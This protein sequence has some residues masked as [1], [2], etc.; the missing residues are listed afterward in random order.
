MK[1]YLANR[2][3][4]APAL[5]NAR[6]H[7]HDIFDITDGDRAPGQL[8]ALSS[9]LRND[10]GDVDLVA[11]GPPCQGFSGIGHRRTFTGLQ[12][13]EIPSN[14]LYR[15]MAAF[16]AA[17]RPKLF[18]FENVKGLLSSRWTAEGTKGEVWADVRA[19]LGNIPERH[20]SPGYD[21]RWAVVQAKDYGVPQN[22]PRVLLVG[23]RRDLGWSPSDGIAD[24]LLP[25][26]AGERSP[27]PCDFLGDL[28]DPDYAAKTATLTY[29]LPAVSEMQ[30]W[31]RTDV[32]G[33]VAQI[34][35]PLTE[36]EYS[37]HAPRIVQK[38][39][40]MLRTGTIREEDRTKKFA[41]RVLPRR[42]GDR[43][44]TITATSLPDDYVHFEQPRILTVREWARLQ[45]FPDDYMFEGKRTTGGRRRAGNP[46]RGDWSRELPKYT[47]IGNAVPVRL[48]EAV[49]THLRTL[50]TSN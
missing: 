40:H 13:V 15:E 44:P 33:R 32:R 42:W 19:Y 49:G 36:Q 35:D 23:V 46:T 6:N 2:N 28:L 43:G 8:S 11:G 48:A 5:A 4:S 29:P 50:I 26:P 17:V 22:R 1:T 20:G 3:H 31:Y 39:D 24:G 30:H 37:R 16:I 12:K 41:Q 27:D 14:H 25:R 45:T 7:V 10:F 38:F 18:L 9:R 47:Q 21:I 34:G